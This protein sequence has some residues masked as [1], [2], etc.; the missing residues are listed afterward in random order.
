VLVVLI[1]KH[2][3]TL[4]LQQQTENNQIEYAINNF[5]E[6][7]FIGMAIL[8]PKHQNWIRFNNRLAEMLKY[9]VEELSALNL[10]QLMSEKDSAILNQQFLRLADNSCDGFSLESYLR[11]KNGPDIF[12]IINAKFVPNIDGSVQFILATIQDVTDLK[13]LSKQYSKN[14]SH[15]NALIHTIPDLVWLKDLNGV[16]LNCNPMFERFFGAPEQ[17]IL[18]KTDYDFVDVEIADCFRKNDLNAMQQDR[19]T[20]N[21]EWLTFADDS[22]KGLFSTIKTP[23]RDDSGKV[24]GVLGVARD[25]TTRKQAQI[26]LERLTK[27]YAALSETSASVVR[28]KNEQDLFDSICK[29]AVSVGDFKMAW[30]GLVNQPSSIIKPVAFSGIHTDY[31]QDLDISTDE[32][33]S[34]GQ[35]PTGIAIRENHPYWCQDFQHD[36]H[37]LKWHIKGKQFG[38]NASASLPIHSEGKVIGALTLY[39]DVLNAFDTPAKGLL[40]EMSTNIGL[41]LDGF[42]HQKEKLLAEI[43]REEV[44]NRLFKLA[45][46]LPGMV[47]Q[48]R[49]RPDGSSNIPFSSNAI[50]EIYGLTPEDVYSDASKVF[51]IIHPE[52]LE[53]MTLSIQA[54]AKSLTSWY[55]EFR[56][57]FKDG[58]VRWL[59][60]NAMPEKEKDGSVLWHGFITDIT[61]HKQTLAQVELASKVFEQSREGI[62]ITDVDHNIIMVNQAFTEIS[63]Y[64]AEEALGRKPKILSSGK[65]SEQ[66]YQKLWSDIDQAGFWQGEIWNRRKNGEIFPEWLSISKGLNQSGQVSEYVAIFSDISKIKENEEKIQRLAHYD[67]LTNLVNRQLM[68][69]RLDHAISSANRSNSSVSLLFIDLDHFKNVNDTLGHHIGD[70]LL[71]EV[72]NRMSGLLRTEDTLARQ[73]GDE[74]IVVLPGVG[75]TGASHVAEKIVN[76]ISNRIKI[77]SYELFVT[78]SIGV[79]V[80]P[81]DGKDVASLLRSADAA[82][83]QAKEDGRNTYRFFTQIMQQRASR[84]ML[85]E[86]ALRTALSR[87]E[88]SLNYQPQVCTTTGRIV[89]AEAL[90]R[91]THPELGVISPIE[92]ISVAEQSGQ[93]LNLSRWVLRS[94]LEYLKSVLEQGYAPFVMAVNLSAVDFQQVDLPEQV[95]KIVEEVNVSSE[96]LALELTESVA[97]ANAEMAIEMMS[98]LTA[99]GIKIA[100]DDFGTGYSSLSYLKKLNASKVKIDQSFVRELTNNDEDKAIV[101]AIISLAHSLGLKAI[102]EGVETEE[103]LAFLKAE[104]CDEIQGYYFSKPLS[105]D[106]FRRYLTTNQS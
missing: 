52:D 75:E 22:Y 36:P 92:F 4:A 49:L 67:P 44:Y 40:L 28:C 83:Y 100:I 18:G 54:S 56:V 12:V 91:W 68:M 97:M 89:G 58:T 46:R 27:L 17:D 50:K 19:S 72:A 31:L 74:F 39:S 9:S 64:S 94:A 87:N 32:T 84:L 90:I 61:E 106:D 66:F 102:A 16:Y 65:H 81:Q 5:Y 70:E 99:N 80:Y 71:V 47:Y 26:Q 59:S 41:G 62:M 30:I 101:K 63:G 8:E 73:G 42:A 55:K 20:E 96:F 43:E 24:V 33:L 60:G 104:G 51:E 21:E 7:P 85:I 13:V 37:T 95:M 10:R 79:A 1:K 105:D 45:D 11:P 53:D 23:M 77:G 6:L 57:K 35:G 76:Q 69:D 29:A 38:W 25:I 15:L 2:F 98:K 34:S 88:L 82:M 93:I 3:E 86:N 48:F 78:P 103:Q 14:Q